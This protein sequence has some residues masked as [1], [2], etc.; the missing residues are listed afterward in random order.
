MRAG[1]ATS[2][3]FRWSLESSVGR[4]PGMGRKN[5]RVRNHLYH[6][7]IC[8]DPDRPCSSSTTTT[9]ATSIPSPRVS[10]MLQ[11][12]TGRND[13]V[14][15][16]LPRLS[17]LSGRRATATYP[18]LPPKSALLSPRTRLSARSWLPNIPSDPPTLHDPPQDGLQVLLGPEH[19]QSRPRN[20]LKC[21]TPLTDILPATG[22][23]PLRLLF[24]ACRLLRQKHLTAGQSLPQESIFCV[25]A[26]YGVYLY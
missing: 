21:E 17:H 20:I 12:C 1:S 24:I 5:C 10:K 22:I 16:L 14:P 23:D 25:A 4:V 2:L 13:P 26:A 19:G 7:I 11:I 3:W 6:I 18:S 9:V 15:P 8:S